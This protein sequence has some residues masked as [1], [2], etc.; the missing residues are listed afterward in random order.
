MFLILLQGSVYDWLSTA[1]VSL[2]TCGV[3]VSALY[4]VVNALIKAMSKSSDIPITISAS[5]MIIIGLVE[6]GVGILLIVIK[7]IVKKG[8][9]KKNENEKEIV[10]EDAETGEQTEAVVTI[11]NEKDE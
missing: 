2:I 9:A 4:I 7:A 10:I 11:E 3:F 8:L 6:F 5:N 1:G